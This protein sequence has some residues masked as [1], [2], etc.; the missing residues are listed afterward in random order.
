MQP[1]KQI[2]SSAFAFSLANGKGRRPQELLGSMVITVEHGNA[3]QRH[4]I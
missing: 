4:L 1:L 3:A 2:A